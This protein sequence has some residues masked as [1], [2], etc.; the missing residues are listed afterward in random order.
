MPRN[1]NRPSIAL[2]RCYFCGDIHQI[3][4]GK[5]LSPMRQVEEMHGKVIS[6]RPCAKCEDLMKQ[7]I[8]LIGIIHG[9]SEKGWNIPPPLPDDRRGW[10]PNPYRSG[11]WAVMKESAFMRLFK[12]DSSGAFGLKHR[13][14]FIEHGAGV[15]I[16]MWDA[17]PTNP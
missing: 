17:L 8:I 9:K 3:V 15:Q 14:M 6:M 11:G 4:I 2:A 1:P 12:P 16:G 7:G 10:M 5:Y 13:W